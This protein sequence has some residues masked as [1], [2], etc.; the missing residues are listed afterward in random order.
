MRR[1]AVVFLTLCLMLGMSIAAL[2]KKPAAVTIHGAVTS[3]DLGQ[4][5]FSTD[6][7]NHGKL[8]FTLAQKAVITQDGSVVGFGALK[9]GDIV[10]VRYTESD[11]N[12]EASLVDIQGTPKPPHPHH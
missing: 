12:K 5:T 8:T 6:G 2:A 11:G 1:T 4:S 9:V 10:E 7:K 3:I